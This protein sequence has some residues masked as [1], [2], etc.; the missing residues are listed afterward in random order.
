MDAEEPIPDAETDD[1]PNEPRLNSR[2]FARNW[3]VYAGRSG[4]ACSDEMV[5]PAARLARCRGVLELSDEADAGGA[6]RAVGAG[7]RRGAEGE[8]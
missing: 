1:A 2:L 8:G 4:G 5:P 6:A 7:D 3:S